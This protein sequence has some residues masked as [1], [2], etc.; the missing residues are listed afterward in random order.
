[1]AQHWH[2]QCSGNGKGGNSQPTPESPALLQAQ[3]AP[4]QRSPKSDQ[5][6]KAFCDSYG[7]L[8]LGHCSAQASS[9]EDAQAQR[10]VLA[11]QILIAR[12]AEALRQ[13]RSHHEVD[14]HVPHL[15]LTVQLLLQTLL[16][17]PHIIHPPGQVE[18]E[19][20]HGQRDLQEQWRQQLMRHMFT[21]DSER[22]FHLQA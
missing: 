12:Q 8:L 22:S 4:G 6:M 11:A 18:Y 17:P 5:C 7:A 20:R 9:S 16:S 13:P 21:S 10:C 2:R 1:M 14:V 15:V 19:R 3:A